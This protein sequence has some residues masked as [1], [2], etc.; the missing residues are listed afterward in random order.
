MDAEDR[1]PFAKG[2]INV[3]EIS[4]ETAECSEALYV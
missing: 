1:N 3:T 2:N 4:Q